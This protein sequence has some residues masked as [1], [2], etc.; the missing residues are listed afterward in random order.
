MPIYVCTL[1]E[2]EDF[3]TYTSDKRVIGSIIYDH[4]SDEERKSL[5]LDKG[6]STIGAIKE[7]QIENVKEWYANKIISDHKPR[8]Q[9][10]IRTSSTSSDPDT[11]KSGDDITKIRGYEEISSLLPSSGVVKI[12]K[13][14]K[15]KLE[16]LGAT[17]DDA[18]GDGGSYAIRFILPNGKKG[19][20]TQGMSNRAIVNKLGEVFIDSTLGAKMNVDI[21]NK[22]K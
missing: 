5:S 12:D 17:V 22:Y 3:Q 21:Y 11:P 18:T 14:L 6:L 8:P 13:D 10:T 20:L 2:N 9:V 4:M 1:F 16:E 15:T 7:K 19:Y